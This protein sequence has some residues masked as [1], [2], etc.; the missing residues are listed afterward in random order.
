MAAQQTNTVVHA[1]TLSALAGVAHGFFT[2][3]ASQDETKGEANCAFRT[4]AETAAVTAARARCQA[5]L[6]ADCLVTVKQRHTADV[7]TV[8]E[9]FTWDAAPIADAL[10][11]TQRGIA[12][13]M[14]TADCAPVLLADTDNG[15]I[16]AA[17]AGWR[18]AVDGVIA[19]TVAAMIAAG[20]RAERIVAAV[21]PCIGVT[22]YEVGP[23]FRETFLARD[24]AF[25]AYFDRSRAKPHFNL[26]AFVAGRLRAAGVGS[27][28]EQG[29]DTMADEAMFFSFRRTTVRGEP[30]YGRQLSAIAL[31]V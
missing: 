13:G 16:A 25:D 19:N 29:S 22:S 31:A 8:D 17:H 11:T 30:D 18:G 26:P 21:G 10:V 2:R 24:P 15:V 7:V 6:N 27:V 20:A 14:L 3:N 28:S 4:P 9:P 1:P 12:L 5:A 23:E